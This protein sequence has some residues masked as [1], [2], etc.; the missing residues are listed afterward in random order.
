MSRKIS[1]TLKRIW[2]LIAFVIVI[3]IV[4]NTNILFQKLK[5]EERLKMELWAMA[6]KDF[7]ENKTPNSITFE[8]LQQI[9]TNPMIQVNANNKI[10]DFKNFELALGSDSIRLYNSLEK[11]KKE[12]KPIIIEYRDSLSG[13]LLVDQ[14]LYYGDSTLLTKLQYYPLALFLIIMLFGLLLY[15]IFKTNKISEQN[16]LWAAMAKETAHQIGTPLSSLIGWTTL[17]KEGQ[18]PEVSISEMEKDIDRLKIITERFSNIGSDP[19]L[20]FQDV[21]SIIKQTVI[22]IQNRSS[23]LTNI[24]THLTEESTIAPVNNQL[25][26]WTIENLIKNGI[27]AMKGEGQILVSSYLNDNKLIILVKDS[28]EGI[29]S[30]NFNKIFSPGFT[31]KKRGWGLG[32][33]LAKRIIV[34]YHRGKIYLKKS[35]PKKGTTI[36]IELLKAG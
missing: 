22:Y 33:S 36:S 13:K 26:S 16:S 11:I 29:K 14:K 34:D 21:N 20:E 27:D 3:L 25:L 12:N 28:G 10:I 19:V 32:L 23:D 18:K 7:I 5:K 8:I 9:G 31:T 30:E 6:Q 35:I 2:P 15:F 17:M 4:W 1:L 24:K